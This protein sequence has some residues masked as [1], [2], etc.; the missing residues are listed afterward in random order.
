[1]CFDTK[2]DEMSALLDG[3]LSNMLAK[4]PDDHIVCL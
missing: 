1:M 4:Y 2:I 3:H